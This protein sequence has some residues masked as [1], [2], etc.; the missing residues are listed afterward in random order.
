MRTRHG[1]YELKVKFPVFSGYTI[2]VVLT[3]DL[4]ASHVSRYGDGGLADDA[5]T[6][7]F[8]TSA[9]TGHS[10]LFC[11][12]DAPAG[13]LTHEAWHAIYG[14]FE[15]AGAELDNES[16]AYHLGYLVD[17]IAQFQA[18]VLLVKSKRRR[19]S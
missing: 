1:D 16:V 13:I 3:S 8:Y 2:H 6:A 19:K 4:R 5:S 17:K 15:W 18:K 11:T 10:H 14:M 9:G 12:K 7:A